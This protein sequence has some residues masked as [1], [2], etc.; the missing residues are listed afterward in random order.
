MYKIFG[1]ILNGANLLNRQ[2][3]RPLFQSKNYLYEK[4]GNKD[5][6]KKSWAII[7]GGSD[8]IGL[9]MSQNLAK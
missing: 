2:F 4:Y 7:T 9:A 3:L 8:G 1:W 6:N 5:K